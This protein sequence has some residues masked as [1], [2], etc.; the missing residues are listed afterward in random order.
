[1]KKP[2]LPYSKFKRNEGSTIVFSAR[3][4]TNE[5]V[6]RTPSTLKWR[7]DDLT[8]NREIVD[9]TEITGPSS[10]NEITISRENN[11]KYSRQQEKE[12]RQL[13]IYT[14]DSNGN[15]AQDIFHYTLIRIFDR[16]AQEL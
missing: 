5:K 11:A 15:D 3:H 14:E 2:V 12:L 1:M 8:N 7:L 16:E 13:T 10:T 4:L 9:W 6:L